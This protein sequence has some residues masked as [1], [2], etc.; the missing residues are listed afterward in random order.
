MPQLE[1]LTMYIPLSYSPPTDRIAKTIISRWQRTALK[2]VE[3]LF[4]NH[5]EGMGKVRKQLEQCIGVGLKVVLRE[6]T[7]PS[8]ALGTWDAPTARN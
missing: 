8:R 6:A 1:H 5:C 7:T 3:I 2:S 4:D